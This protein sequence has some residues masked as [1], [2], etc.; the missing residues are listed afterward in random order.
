MN[1]GAMNTSTS[2]TAALLAALLL[3]SAPQA[4][5][6][7]VVVDPRRPSP[8]RR[9]PPAYP[10]PPPPRGAL[11]TTGATARAAV[12]VVSLSATPA[13]LARPAG[14]EAGMLASHNMYR[15]RHGVA[16]LMWNASL[17]EIASRWAQEL[18]DRHALVPSNSK[19][20]GENLAVGSDARRSVD[21]WYAEIRNYSHSRPGFAARHFTQVVWRGTT[22]LGCAFASMDKDGQP[23]RLAIDGRLRLAQPHVCEYFPAGNVL[24]AWADNAPELRRKRAA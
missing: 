24:S 22:Q 16:A 2:M 12:V 14:Y 8:P 11:A 13:L 20:L 19:T 15:A 17:A 1:T 5:A 4:S 9:A 6:R 7:V 23:C 21:Q 10:P 3:I 18:C